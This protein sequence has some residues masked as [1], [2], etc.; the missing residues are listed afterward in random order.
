M[1][2]HVKMYN[3]CKN[4]LIFSIEEEVT[5][6]LGALSIDTQKDSFIR[7]IEEE[8]EN[9]ENARQNEIEKAE[10]KI[11]DMKQES[12]QKNS[13]IRATKLIDQLSAERALLKDLENQLNVFREYKN[14]LLEE[15]KSTKYDQYE[16]D[17]MKNDFKLESKRFE[18]SLPIYAKKTEILD[19]I[20]NWPVTILTAETGSG[21]STQVVQYLHQMD[22]SAKIICTQPRKVAATSLAARVSDEMGSK[23]GEEVGYR[24]GARAKEGR[25]TQ[26]MYVTDHILLNQC[27]Y[28]RDLRKYKYVIVDEAHERS[29]STDLLLA[30]VKKALRRRPSMR[31]IISSATIDPKVFEDYFVGISNC[32]HVSGRTYPVEAIYE[33]LSIGMDYLKIAVE[34]AKELHRNE[35]AGGDVLVFLTTPGETE[36]AQDIMTSDPT[37]SPEL[38]CLVLHGR[39]QPEEQQ[40]V[41]EPTPKWKRKIVFATN[42]AETSI[43]IP[44]IKYVIDSGM[45]K[46]KHYDREKNASLLKVGPVNKSSAEQRM[47]RAGRTQPGKCYRLYTEEEFKEMNDSMLPEILRENLG[48]A[49]LKLYEFDIGD[50]FNYEFVEAPP[51]QAL[52]MAKQELKDLDA[53]KNGS[54]TRYGRIMASLDLEPKLGKFVALCIDMEIGIDAMVIAAVCSVGGSVFFRAGTEDEKQM[55]DRLKTRFLNSIGDLFTFLGVYKEWVEIPDLTK[56]QWCV[57]NSMNAKSLRFARDLVNDMKKN[58]ENLLDVEISDEFSDLDDLKDILP[59]N[60]VECFKSSLAYYSGHERGGYYRPGLGCDRFYLHPSATLSFLNSTPKWILFTEILTTN[61]NYLI[62]SI[63][64]PEVMANKF[65]KQSPVRL[66]KQ[67]IVG[68]KMAESLGLGRLNCRLE[69]KLQQE[70]DQNIYIDF[71]KNNGTVSLHC[72]LD[73]AQKASIQLDDI[74]KDKRRWIDL[75]RIEIPISERNSTCVVIEKGGVCSE[76]LFQGEFCSL[77]I[78][79]IKESVKAEQVEKEFEIFGEIVQLIKFFNSYYWGK[80]TFAKS[81][82]AAK[83]LSQCK[84]RFVYNIDFEDIFVKA[85]FNQ[86]IVSGGTRYC[87]VKATWTR[88]PAKGDFAFV[89]FQD[90]KMFNEFVGE[91]KLI[92]GRFYSFKSGKNSRPLSLKMTEISTYATQEELKLSIENQF[93]HIKVSSCVIPR[94]APRSIDSKDVIDAKKRQISM[95]LQRC[96]PSKDGERFRIEMKPVSNEKQCEYQ[97]K[98][99]CQ[100]ANDCQILIN[101]NM[102]MGLF[103]KVKFTPELK[104]DQISIP[105]T[106]YH[107]VKEDLE[108]QIRAMKGVR[109]ISN[110]KNN[111]KNKNAPKF[112]EIQ[113]EAKQIETL[114]DANKLLLDVVRGE[115]VQCNERQFRFFKTPIGRE[116]IEELGSKN[117]CEIKIERRQRSIIIFGNMECRRRLGKVITKKKKE[118]DQ[119]VYNVWTEDFSR[120]PMG[121]IKRFI[122]KYGYDLEKLY[123]EITGIALVNINFFCHTIEFQG[124]K[125]ALLKCKEVIC[126]L[127]DEM[128][129]TISSKRVKGDAAEQNTCPICFDDLEVTSHQL[130]TCSHSYCVE[131]YSGICQHAIQNKKLPLICAVEGCNSPFSIYD[132]TEVIEPKNIVLVAV[133]RYIASH[134]DMY[135]YCV[136]PD[137]LNIYRAS[138]TPNPDEPF[139]C[140]MCEVQ[141]CTFCHKKNHTGLTCGLEN[142]KDDDGLSEW[143]HGNQENRGLCPS[144][145]APIERA[146]GCRHIECSVCRKHVCWRCKRASFNTSTECY[147]HLAR[148]GGGN[149]GLFR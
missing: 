117:A 114:R 149:M 17:Q 118:M 21:K 103:A 141:I 91:R 92:G 78:K 60:L 88:I 130:E 128:E 45:V 69:T 23:V 39:L 145:T 123:K 48:L 132:L 7:H 47:G 80:I 136:T 73:V 76:V 101:S 96:L 102:T 51:K 68:K 109:M 29:I 134:Q 2:T 129:A 12:S 58:A 27:L 36:R 90:Q 1:C 14:Q 106:V 15:L 67:W 84:R 127:V 119:Q 100:N 143:L 147:D 83:A 75:D 98:I 41:F 10:E 116:F 77:L 82:Q 120:K 89:T 125:D 146:D 66:V 19:N 26:I 62:N 139:H 79:G 35:P 8:F 50:P 61:R 110:E 42:S 108:K 131:C 148:C 20:R 122:K 111:K 43:T 133:E 25:N 85:C 5:Y 70:I 112:V 95:H 52:N 34:K 38:K 97:A 135:K 18:A 44:N 72:S 115:Q 59:V 121:F 3:E 74:I 49:M 11:S 99:W 104:T 55:S 142:R 144:C 105:I 113:L 137:C 30:M 33:N 87:G 9:F 13:L 81:S 65:I 86:D 4:V 28:D 64:I 63:K 22:P 31:L 53:I 16:L 6:R 46:E 57:E 107:Y 94:E 54:L 124:D 32:I 37:I 93:P 140:M 126:N 40:L 24:I 71:D 138:K 56:S